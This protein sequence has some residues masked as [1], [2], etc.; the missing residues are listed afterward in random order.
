MKADITLGENEF[1]FDEE[2]GDVTIPWDIAAEQNLTYCQYDVIFVRF[3]EDEI[4]T[5]G[6]YTMTGSNEDG[7]VCEFETIIATNNCRA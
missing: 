7:I 6:K 3:V 5:I 1:F 2:T 4:E